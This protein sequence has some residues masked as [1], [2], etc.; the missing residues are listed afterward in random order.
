M[1]LALN[2]Y[3]SKL[4]SSVRSKKFEEDANITDQKENKTQ[5]KQYY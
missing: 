4:G 1:K 5:V 2:N 3:T